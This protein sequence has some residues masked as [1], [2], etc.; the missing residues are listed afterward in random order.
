[1]KFILF[2]LVVTGALVFLVL[3]K[4]GASVEMP[5][6]LPGPAELAERVEGLFDDETDKSEPAPVFTNTAPVEAV[7]GDDL[8]P[9]A[10]SSTPAEVVVEEILPL[11]PVE[12]APEPAKAPAKP[13][14]L[15]A[16]VAPPPGLAPDVA[17]RRAEVLGVPKPA[18]RPAT[19]LSAGARESLTERR[20]KLESLAEEMELMSA[21][22]AIR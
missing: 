10:K 19:S 8:A 1:M 21:G 4:E 18:V 7:L 15:V 17:K 20:L 12:E 5:V 3:D 11:A 16:E 22:A 9:K 13:P 2:N 6:N 14:V